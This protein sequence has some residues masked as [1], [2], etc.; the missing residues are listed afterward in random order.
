[1][2]RASLDS[3]GTGVEKRVGTL[4]RRGS[5]LEKGLDNNDGDWRRF[6]NLDGKLKKINAKIQK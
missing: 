5:I 6:Q 1:L 4:E 3:R 2:R